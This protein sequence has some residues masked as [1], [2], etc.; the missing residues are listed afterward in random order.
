MAGWSQ[1]KGHPA[2][3]YQRSGRKGE[4]A[5]DW[6]PKYWKCVLT[7]VD[8]TTPTAEPIEWAFA[9]PRRLARIKLVDGPPLDLAPLSLLGSDPLLAM[10][11]IASLSES[12]AK[13]HAPIK[14][15]LLD[16]NGPLCG[17]G[18]WMADEILYQAALHPSHPSS[19]LTAVELARLHDQIVHVVKSA[20]DVDADSHRFP[21]HWLFSSRWGKGK[22]KDEFVLPSGKTTKIKFITVGGRTSAVIEEVQKMP[23]GAKTSLKTVK[24]TPVGSAKQKAVKDEVEAGDVEDAKPA[25]PTERATKRASHAVEAEDVD[26][27]LPTKRRRSARNSSGH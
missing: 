11:S 17:I 6:P 20:T 14:A 18:N 13:R 15:V 3:Q 19:L 26:D 23:K 12:L 9:D 27:G 25:K 1:Q 24:R 2:P 10:P 5:T 21:A 7:L 8:P 22:G 4:P 16:Q